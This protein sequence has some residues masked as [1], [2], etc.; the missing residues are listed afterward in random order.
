MCDGHVWGKRGRLRSHW[1]CLWQNHQFTKF[2]REHLHI[3][4]L[5]PWGVT[6]NL[7]QGQE[8]WCHKMLLIVLYLDTRYNVYGFNTLGDTTICLFHVTFDLHLWPLTSVKVTC[9]LINRC[10]SCCWMFEPKMK[11]VGSVE[12]GIW[13][14]VWRKLYWRH[15][16]VIT[17]LILMKFI[18]KSAKSIC[19]RH[20]KF[21]FDQ[22]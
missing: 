9:T 14:F 12:F 6:L 22:T 18:Y 21:Q 20:P 16:D 13:T 10:I 7:R 11:F 17:N 2:Q 15:Y 5:W 4:D 8:S 3:C 19:K 1:L